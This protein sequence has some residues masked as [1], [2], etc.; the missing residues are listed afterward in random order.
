MNNYD[1]KIEIN[2]MQ[3]RNHIRDQPEAIK[4]LNILRAEGKQPRF[5][6]DHDFK[7][8]LVVAEYVVKEG[9]VGLDAIIGNG[10]MLK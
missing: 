7:A 9:V 8:R 6:I 1:F 10:Y 3:Y 2:E 5:F 4:Q